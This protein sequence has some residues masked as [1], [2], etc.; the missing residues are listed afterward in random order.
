MSRSLISI[1][2]ALAM[3]GCAAAAQFMRP[4]PGPAPE[5]SLED[6][7]PRQFA[8]WTMDADVAPVPPSPDVQANLDKLYSEILTR[9]Y[10]NERGERMM[11]VIAYGGD[12]SDSLKAHRQE[13]CYSAQGFSIRQVRDDTMRFA[14]NEVPLV[15]VHAVKGRRSEPVSYWFT[16]GDRVA[17]SRTDRL[18]TQIGHGLRGQVPDGLLVRVSSLSRDPAASY[19]AHD[20][21]LRD[22]LGVV[23]PDARARLAGQL[24]RA[25]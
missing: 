24:D 11:L 23:G 7:I 8:G 10:V 15:R 16:M 13:F 17:I 3:F 6:A 22:L 19:A 21:F 1:V 12:Q 25:S 18:L 20:A 14:G 9:A 2:A 4:E 5:V